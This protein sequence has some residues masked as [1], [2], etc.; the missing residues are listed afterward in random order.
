M[1][2]YG[3]ILSG[4]VQ[5]YAGGVL[6]KEERDYQ[7]KQQAKQNELKMYQVI[8]DSPDADPATKAGAFQKV[9]DLLHGAGNGKKS[10]GP[11]LLS[12]IGG[13]FT[14]GAGQQNQGGGQP[15]GQP[16]SQPSGPQGPAP[17]S[18]VTPGTNGQI[19][20]PPQK[21]QAQGMTPPPTGFSPHFY[22]PEEKA[23]Q[24]TSELDAEQAVRM[25]YFTQ[26]EELRK[27]TDIAVEEA[28]AK[29]R[30]YKSPVGPKPGGM[31]WETGQTI[32]SDGLPT[33]VATNPPK[34]VQDTHQMADSLSRTNG[35]SVLENYDAIWTMKAQGLSLDQIKK[36]VTIDATQKKSN[37]GDYVKVQDSTGEFKWI[38]KPGADTA[39][40][41]TQPTQSGLQPPPTKQV[42]GPAASTSPPTGAT[43]LPPTIDSGVRGKMPAGRATGG[44]RGKQPN[45]VPIENHKNDLMRRVHEAAVKA[46]SSAPDD[47]ARK[48]I[49]AHEAEQKAQI[50]KDYEAA[51]ATALSGMSKPPGKT[52]KMK[53][54]N[55][56]TRDVAVDQVAH[57]QSLGATVV[58]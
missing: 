55:G 8:L 41:P 33:W 13:M 38:K 47:T 1:P 14:Q 31:P 15:S 3:G 36:Q 10:Q 35:K 17:T 4:L 24:K 25:K 21:P 46:A 39:A 19:Q 26:Q 42:T 43:T 11:G 29:G 6:Q 56:R 52:I 5:G 16:A 28:R 58:Q 51:R 2:G 20:P 23:A 57:F 45:L 12:K 30:Q 37:E 34:D 32:V 44:G 18:P 49:W 7:E 22:S 9:E 27:K 53:A 50:Q 48:A 40:A 54:P